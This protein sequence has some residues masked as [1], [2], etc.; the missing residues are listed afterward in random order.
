M[1]SVLKKEPKIEEEYSED[2]IELLTDEEDDNLSN[3]KID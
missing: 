3:I 1:L 2:D